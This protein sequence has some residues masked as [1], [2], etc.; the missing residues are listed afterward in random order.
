MSLTRDA[1]YALFEDR[2]G[3]LAAY[4]AMADE[5]DDL[6]YAMI[7]HAFRWMCRRGKFPHQ[8]THYTA[9]TSRSFGSGLQGRKVPGR[10]RWAWYTR[11]VADKNVS[12]IWPIVPREPHSLP[13]LVMSGEQRVYTSHQAAVMDL[14]KWLQRLRDAYD[15]EP[16][17]PP[18]V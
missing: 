7:G 13:S 2:P 6:G 10:Y 11:D 5:M 18:G 12:G 8:R 15:V 16:P 9:Y 3:D 4:G 14:A 17:K 1:M